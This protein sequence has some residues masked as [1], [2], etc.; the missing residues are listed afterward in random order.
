MY[1][2]G[3]MEGLP[4]GSVV[5]NL[6][7]KHWAPKNWCFWT[8]ELV[9]NREAWCAAVHGVAKS[10]TQLRNWTAKQEMLL[11]SLGG[12]EPLGQK[13]Q[14][15]PIFLPGKSR[16]QRKLAGRHRWCRFHPWIGKIPWRR[17]WQPT[18]VC[19]PGES[20]G[21]RSLA[22]Y[23][24]RGSQRVRHNW[25]NLAHTHTHTHTPWTSEK[26]GNVSSALKNRAAC[27]TDWLLSRCSKAFKELILP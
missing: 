3:R 15:T 11:W 10:Q 23:S 6:P 27:W 21:Q 12:E 7:A 19:L 16:G 2:L 22:G 13:W 26:N 9:M 4:G 1:L 8:M 5:K 14:F 18:P 24:P 25:S 20:H 17:A